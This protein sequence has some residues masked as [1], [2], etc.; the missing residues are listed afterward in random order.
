[1]FD[2]AYDPDYLEDLLRSVGDEAKEGEGRQREHREDGQGPPVRLDAYGTRVWNGQHHVQNEY[3][4]VDRSASLYKIS[5]VLSEAGASRKIIVEALKERDV[6][7]GWEKYSDRKNPEEQYRRIVDKLEEKAQ[8]TDNVYDFDEHKKEKDGHPDQKAP[9][10]NRVMLDELVENGLKDPEELIE[11][12]LLKGKAHHLFADA[13]SGKTFVALNLAMEVLKQGKT[14]VYLDKE[15]GPR[16]MAQRVISMGM[17]TK[18][19]GNLLHYHFDFPTPCDEGTRRSYEDMLDHIEPDLVVFDSWIGFL[20]DA[21]LDENVSR[22]IQ[23]WANHYLHPARG[24][25][26]TT[27]ILDHVPHDA[28]RSRGSGRKKEEVDVQWELH[29]SESFDRDKVGSIRLRRKKDREGWLPE[30]VSFRLGGEDGEFI[31]EREHKEQEGD[32]LSD[33][34]RKVLKILEGMF[35]EG[36]KTAQWEKA[37]KEYENIPESTFYEC[38]KKLIEKG[39]VEKRNEKFYPVY[40]SDGWD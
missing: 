40:G 34:Q 12:V 18:K 5:A 2:K 10:G 23:K 6:S 33:A 30:V 27:L 29:N 14:A 35:E 25:E 37:C 24:R 8:N 31:F 7:L 32:G 16:T 11:G 17:N 15:N 26:I 38:R 1:M 3:G 36:A 39:R 13:G 4:E 28:R 9:F 22:D 20:S 19:S 21:D